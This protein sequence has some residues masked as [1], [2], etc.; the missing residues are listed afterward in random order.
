MS[1]PSPITSSDQLIAIIQTEVMRLAEEDG[2]FAVR[3]AQIAG[4]NMPTYIN[5]YAS[6]NELYRSADGHADKTFIVL[7]DVRLTFGETMQKAAQLSNILANDFSVCKGGHVAIAMRNCPEWVIAFIAIT[8]MRAVAVPLNSWWQGD[9]L[10]HALHDSQSRLLITDQMIFTRLDDSSPIPCLVAGLNRPDQSQAADLDGLLQQAPPAVFPAD[11][12]QPDDLALILYTSGSTGT[13]KGVMSTHRAIITALTVWQHFGAAASGLMGTTASPVQPAALCS[14][15]LF[16]VTGALS[17]LLHSLL[18]GRKLVMMYKWDAEKALDLIEAEQITFFNGAPAMI[19]DLVASDLQGRDLSSLGTIGGAGA[20]T[21]PD[22]IGKLRQIFPFVTPQNGYG[23]TETNAIGTLLAAEAYT[24]RPG[25]AGMPNIPIVEIKLLGDDGEEVACGEE[26]EIIIK[27][28]SNFCGYWNNPDATTATLK[29]GWVHTSDIGR[30]DDV[31][32]LYIM[33]R[34]KD[35][36]IRGG[37]NIS[38]IEVEAAI[39]E[40]DAVREAAV[41]ACPDAR[42]GETV[43]TAI[44][45]KSGHALSLNSLREVLKKKLALYK[46]PEQLYLCSEPLPRI[47]SGKINRR[48][49]QSRLTPRV[50]NTI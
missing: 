25:S 11:H 37:E 7:D 45:L 3:D 12:S 1:T 15:P 24:D 29:N 19:M 35:L 41:F 34:K 6:L 20:A 48:Q 32:C 46:L 36:I 2:P 40:L 39:S 28:A 10:R 16:H 47:A 14:M 38:C 31:G 23:M 18:L 21:P 42:L 43:A 4:I 5:T 26:G 22:Q 27:S 30:L 17:Q 33:G 8:A 49:L 44:Y 9:E 50:C 13:P